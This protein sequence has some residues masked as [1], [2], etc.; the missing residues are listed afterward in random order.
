M[1]AEEFS[2]LENLATADASFTDMT[3]VIE[4]QESK[5]CCLAFI[6][7]LAEV[8]Q[9]LSNFSRMS[10]LLRVKLILHLLADT[11]LMSKSS[12]EISLLELNSLSWQQPSCL[13][14][15]LIFASIPFS[16]QS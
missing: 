1:L 12:T 5:K 8:L 15:S 11:Y 13:E 7:T 9:T 2:S 6:E 3:G 16:E 10:L 4:Q 14:G